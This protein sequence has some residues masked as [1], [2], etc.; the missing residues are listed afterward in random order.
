M[1][2]TRRSVFAVPTIP[3]ARAL[4]RERRARIAEAEMLPHSQSIPTRRRGRPPLKAKTKR[5]KKGEE[6]LTI[7]ADIDL[8][9]VPQDASYIN[10]ASRFSQN[11]DSPPP[12]TQN[13]ES[14]PQATQVN[15]LPD[16][17]N[18]SR[19][20]SVQPFPPDGSLNPPPPSQAHEAR[21]I[22]SFFLPPQ[23]SQDAIPYSQAFEGQVPAKK[24]FGTASAVQPSLPNP[25]AP[26]FQPIESLIHFAAGAPVSDERKPFDQGGTNDAKKRKIIGD[27]FLVADNPE[28]IS[29][30]S[31]RR[32]DAISKSSLAVMARMNGHDV[33]R[34][35]Y[36]A[37][38][39]AMLHDPE[40]R[41]QLPPALF[42]VYETAVKEESATISNGGIVDKFVEAIEKST[43]IVA[44]IFRTSKNS[45]RERRARGVRN[46]FI[47]NHPSAV[48]G[49]MDPCAVPSTSDSGPAMHLADPPARQPSIPSP[50]PLTEAN[51]TRAPDGVFKAKAKENTVYSDRE[52]GVMRTCKGFVRV[53][54]YPRQA[55]TDI[56][57]M[58][59]ALTGST[60]NPQP[61]ELHDECGYS[62]YSASTAGLHQQSEA[63]RIASSILD[64]VK[65]MH[66]PGSH[67]AQCVRN[68]EAILAQ[69]AREKG[70]KMAASVRRGFDL[71]HCYD[72]LKQVNV[73][74]LSDALLEHISDA[75]RPPR[76]NR[77]PSNS[78]P[79]QTSAYQDIPQPPAQL[80]EHS[81]LGWG[82]LTFAKVFHP[83]GSDEQYT[84][85]IRPPFP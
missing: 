60:N 22:G 1:V 67:D 8:D 45:K 50:E 28:S 73:E 39:D 31:N 51:L 53:E 6:P 21:R 54:P 11:L 40:M 20:T 81:Q 76:I 41:V 52:R 5:Q 24:W 64:G 83:I 29:D 13:F 12:G 18:S 84:E 49:A 80:C 63:K 78:G 62:V 48:S 72:L 77:Q 37:I 35:H 85:T 9:H 75:P 69:T 68:A 7:T 4:T 30:T 46:R 23:G 16:P 36:L 79:M 56:P 55:S 74:L 82:F 61:K 43:T 27:D 33:T 19:Q 38:L 42:E 65:S 59:H 2:T 32:N 57:T 15:F 70:E 10:F 71:L 25:G 47:S 26:I 58:A 17:S 3:V 44:R 66:E 34:S 14:A